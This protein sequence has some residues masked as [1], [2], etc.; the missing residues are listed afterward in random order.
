MGLRKGYA[1]KLGEIALQFIPKGDP[2]RLTYNKLA[3]EVHVDGLTQCFNKTYF[4]EVAEKAV[5]KA[6]TLKTLL[7]IIAFDIDHSK[8]MND[9]YGHDGGDNVLKKLTH[10]L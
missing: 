9:R 5:M 3:M 4:N 7:S 6:R 10:L 1:I 8:Q 2:E